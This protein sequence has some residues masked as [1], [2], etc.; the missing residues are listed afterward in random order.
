MATSDLLSKLLEIRERT[1]SSLDK[2][3]KT[4]DT[5]RQGR[6]QAQQQKSIEQ[7]QELARLQLEDKRRESQPFGVATGEFTPEALANIKKFQETKANLPPMAGVEVP[8]A[9]AEMSAYD[10]FRTRYGFSPETPM[11]L[12]GKISE[13]RKG[14]AEVGKLGAESEKLSAEAA[15]KLKQVA[16]SALDN[17]SKKI[18]LSLGDDYR[19]IS[20]DFQIQGNA[21]NR[22]RASSVEPSAAGDISLIFNYMKLLDPGSTVREG[23]AATVRNAGSIPDRIRA[24]YNRAINGESFAPEIRNDFVR[25]SEL[26]YSSAKKQQS[27]IDEQFR[28]RSE[29]FGIPPELVLI[30]FSSFNQPLDQSSGPTNRPVMP[31]P[32][33]AP[34]RNAPG[35]AGT[36]ATADDILREYGL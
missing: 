3:N 21:Y 26:L 6:V 33:P 36:G 11:S 5:I 24:L 30:D 4:F 35:A 7:Q 12:V 2:L 15:L 31:P 1:P 19:N 22:I 17:D 16:G 29:Q 10:I 9:P 32:A 28:K 8:E 13:T 14:I 25:R 27:I 23:E 18:A 34:G 20:K